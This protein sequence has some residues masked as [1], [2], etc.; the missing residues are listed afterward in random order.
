M[1]P[2]S[3]AEID[4]LWRGLDS[5]AERVGK[6]E[7]VGESSPGPT[8]R[9]AACTALQLQGAEA[10]DATLS[11][12]RGRLLDLRRSLLQD[13]NGSDAESP[14][15]RSTTR[16]GRGAM[17]SGSSGCSTEE[18][19]PLEPRGSSHRGAG[20][21]RANPPLGET[22]SQ[23]AEAQLCRTLLELLGC[24]DGCMLDLHSH[25]TE[26]LGCIDTAA[27]GAGAV[28]PGAAQAAASDSEDG[29]SEFVPSEGQIIPQLPKRTL[30]RSASG[31]R[32]SVPGQTCPTSHNHDASEP[33]SSDGPASTRHSLLLGSA[34][35]VGEPG[36]A[37]AFALANELRGLHGQLH[38]A[39]THRRLQAERVEQLE[40]RVHWLT[41]RVPPSASPALARDEQREMRA[42]VGRV[43]AAVSRVEER[44][45]HI[46]LV[47]A[48]QPK[49]EVPLPERAWTPPVSAISSL[50]APHLAQD[51]SS[52]SG[53]EAL[54]A[55]RRSKMFKTLVPL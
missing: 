51:P 48:P 22:L 37:G 13:T 4:R 38:A 45:L 49:P 3:D 10:F 35:S 20:P 23:Q 50:L 26:L 1:A 8:C 24:I 6:I 55:S 14:G 17:P 54:T 21:A 11:E 12:V 7:L 43:H 27:S 5:L 44:L 25:W 9:G 18:P 19:D 36:D 41:S 33:S 32:K 53:K 42:E 39:E 46:Q 2:A 30:V 52:V 28:L 40:A 15:S 47:S 16:A 29:H 34:S 31:V